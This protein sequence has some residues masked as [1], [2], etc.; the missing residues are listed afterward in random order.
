MLRLACTEARI[1]TDILY[2]CI[3]TCTSTAVLCLTVLALLLLMFMRRRTGEKKEPLL[4][5]D[6]IRDNIYY[7]DE[8]GGGEDDQVE[9]DRL[10]VCLCTNLFLHC[11]KTPHTFLPKLPSPRT[12]I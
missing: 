5:E 7:Y 11:T 12:M 9:T 2:R 10:C 3:A 1:A 4:Q 8:E 6:D